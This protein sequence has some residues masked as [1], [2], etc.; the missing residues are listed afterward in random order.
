MRLDIDGTVVLFKWVLTANNL[1][2]L[3]DV[4]GTGVDWHGGY[5]SSTSETLTTDG[6]PDGT[7]NAYITVGG[8]KRRVQMTINGS[9][10]LCSGTTT[11]TSTSTT[12]TSSTTSSTTTASPCAEPDQFTIVAEWQGDISK[13]YS[14][15]ATQV[16][17]TYEDS[18]TGSTETLYLDDQMN[19]LRDKHIL[20]LRLRLGY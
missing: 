8:V 3:E 19:G 14:V 7:G 11:T 12:T 15:R 5:G 20:I 13:F 4:T 10:T 1:W 18:T 17:I 2:A 6:K 16:E 9:D